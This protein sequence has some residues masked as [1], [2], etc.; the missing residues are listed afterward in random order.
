MINKNYSLILI[1]FI[2]LLFINSACR[3]SVLA[4]TSTPEPSPVSTDVV[5]GLQKN[6][7]QALK[8]AQTSGQ[9]FLVIT[10]SQLSSIIAYQVQSLE[11]SKIS[12]VQISLRNDRIYM[13]FNL[14]QSGMTAPGEIIV[15]VK[16]DTAGKVKAEIESAKIGPLPLP[17]EL[18]SMI[19][20]EID[21]TLSDQIHTNQG[22]IFI[23]SLVIENGQI[24]IS[25]H[26][27]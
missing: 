5:Q 6:F 8:D 10:E 21:S 12:D 18:K 9:I 19:S 14:H 16:I 11:E 22:D 7:E 4:N 25:G 1:V 20:A 17:A 2:I 3:F 23:D 13:Y 15:S 26:L 24:S 27:R